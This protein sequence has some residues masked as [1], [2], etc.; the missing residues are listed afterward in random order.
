MDPVPNRATG[1]TAG[2]RPGWV[3]MSQGISPVHFIRAPSTKN[4]PPQPRPP[5]TAHWENIIQHRRVMTTLLPLLVL[6]ILLLLLLVLTLHRGAILHRKPFLLHQPFLFNV[7]LFFLIHLY[8][9]WHDVTV[10]TR[11]AFLFYLFLRN[12]KKNNL[13]ALPPL[14][15]LNSDTHHNHTSA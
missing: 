7:P 6:R 1:K 15:E 4:P 12:K 10:I 8:L 2:L 5:Y 14:L 11:M 9:L 13:P 3:E